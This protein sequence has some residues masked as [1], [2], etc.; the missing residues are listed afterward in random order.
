LHSTE[1]VRPTEVTILSAKTFHM[2]YTCVPQWMKPAVQDPFDYKLRPKE[3]I[4][5]EFK[6]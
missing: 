5:E 2:S 6:Y 3:E 1:K 4:A